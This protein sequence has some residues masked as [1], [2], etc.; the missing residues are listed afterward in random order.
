MF[1][2][3]VVN[4]HGGVTSCYC[5]VVCDSTYSDGSGG[6]LLTCCCCCC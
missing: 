5:S 3:V 4:D 6:Q 2:Y 1:L